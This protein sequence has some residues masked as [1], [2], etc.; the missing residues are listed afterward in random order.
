MKKAFAFFF[1]ALSGIYLLTLG[2]F[3]DG[4][5]F[6]DEAVAL[7]I[8]TNAMAALGI[9]LRRWIPGLSQ[10]IRREEKKKESPVVDV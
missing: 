8:F 10:R 4:L 9:D 6:L 7:L 2:I 1:A 5:P 3:P